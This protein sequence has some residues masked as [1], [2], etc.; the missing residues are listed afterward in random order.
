[1]IIRINSNLHPRDEDCAAL[2]R[3]SEC[4]EIITSNMISENC[5]D[6]SYIKCYKC[7]FFE[8]LDEIRSFENL[9]EDEV[10]PSLN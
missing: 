9:E 5:D 3:C 4:G 10:D 8:F 2:Y 1:M 6:C 7:E